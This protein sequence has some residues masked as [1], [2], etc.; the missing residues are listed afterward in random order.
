M[1][2]SYRATHTR[3]LLSIE[4][5]R[6]SPLVVE[7]DIYSAFTVPAMSNVPAR[8]ANHHYADCDQQPARPALIAEPAGTNPRDEF[9]AQRSFCA[10]AGRFTT[11]HVQP[12]AGAPAI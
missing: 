7:D 12:C 1:P 3:P 10:R 6:L 2:Q 5:A 11:L 8:A 4:S 9:P